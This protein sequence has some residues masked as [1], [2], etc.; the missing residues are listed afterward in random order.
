MSFLEGLL[1]LTLN[2][3]HEARSEPHI[4]QLAVAHVT[5]NRALKQNQ[6]VESVVTAP[7]QFSWT[8]EKKSYLPEEPG[9]FI[10]CMESALEAMTGNDFTHGATFYHRQDVNPDWAQHLTFVDQYGVHKFY[11]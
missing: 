3:Y 9:V 1:W 4:G 10:D 11:R 8:L 6:S 7:N 5:L 2:I